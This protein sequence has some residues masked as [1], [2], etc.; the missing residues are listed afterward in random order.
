VWDD[1]DPVARDGVG[2]FEEVDCE[3]AHHDPAFAAFGH[4]THDRSLRGRRSVEDRVQRGDARLA[5]CGEEVED[6][7][8]VRSAEDPVLVLDRDQPDVAV[9]DESRRPSVIALDLSADPEP[10]PLGVLGIEFGSAQRQD[11][12]ADSLVRR[13]HGGTQ[14]MG[15]RADSERD[16]GYVP[17]KAI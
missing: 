9:V 14:V 3:T 2:R 1:P 16:G 13:H 4:L 7:T 5:Q 11:R 12:R 8:A 17:T 6:E 15:E 10:D